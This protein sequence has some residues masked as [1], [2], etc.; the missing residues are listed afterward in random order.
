MGFRAIAYSKYNL[1][2]RFTRR[3]PPCSPLEHTRPRIEYGGLLQYL[4]RR[5]LAVFLKQAAERLLL[6]YHS[7]RRNLPNQIDMPV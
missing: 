7:G 4:P 3:L 2:L 1:L 6:G 5:E